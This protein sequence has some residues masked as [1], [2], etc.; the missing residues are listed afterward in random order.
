MKAFLLAA[1][2]GK[3]LRPITNVIPKCLV[4]LNGKP[5]LQYWIDT[6]EKYEINEVMINLHHLSDK[7]LQYISSSETIISIKTYY[8]KELL[9]SARTI[10]FNSHWVKDEDAFLIIY[11]DNLT[12][13]NLSN[14]IAYHKSKDCPMT[15]SLFQTNRP[16]ECGI[17]GLDEN[18]IITTFEE[19]PSFPQSNLANAG[20]FVV[21]SCILDIF[22]EENCEDISYDVIPKLTGNINGYIIPE[23]II[24]IG[25][26]NNYKMANQVLTSLTF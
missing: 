3:R 19:K 20:I 22:E 23:Y 24:D 16:W 21:N 26:I 5:L 18:R 9:G 25:T 11:A 7:V 10:A 13:L 2:L 1:G 12:N 14:L 6:F 4:P 15:M 17:V 8:E